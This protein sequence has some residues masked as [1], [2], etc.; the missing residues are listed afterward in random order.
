M[1][2]ENLAENHDKCDDVMRDMQLDDVVQG[3][4][5]ITSVPPPCPSIIATN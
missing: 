5:L 1:L 2:L 4:T 3:H